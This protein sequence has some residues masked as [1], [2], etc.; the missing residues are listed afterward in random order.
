MQVGDARSVTGQELVV[1]PAYRD[2]ATAPEEAERLCIGCG[3]KGKKVL[4]VT[5]ATHV[6]PVYWDLLNDGFWFSPT[7]DC[8]VFYYN[9]RDGVYFLKDEVKTRYGLKEREPPRPICYCLQVTEEQI[10]EEIL[11]RGCC[12]SL[13]DIV[14]Y[15]KAG[16][17]KWCLTTNPSGK[18]C[19]EYLLEVVD[20]YLEK[21]GRKPVR[22]DLARVKEQLQAGGP[23]AEISLE[24]GGMTCESCATA[25]KS[26][27]EELGAKEVRVSVKAGEAHLRAP[28]SVP[29]DEVAKAVQDLGYRA[30]VKAVTRLPSPKGA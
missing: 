24:V 19:R 15:T 22:K 11:Q 21:A 12:Y 30:R 4:K 5:A 14:E 7:S 1:S 8:D 28:A 20:R 2:A 27:L 10:E 25:I 6:D 16:T 3:K 9:N 18:C 13:E 26:T 29:P 23:Q 17:G